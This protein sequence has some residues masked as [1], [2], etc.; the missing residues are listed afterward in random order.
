MLKIFPLPSSWFSI[1]LNASGSNDG[2]PPSPPGRSPCQAC[3]LE[4]TYADPIRIHHNR[5][6]L[7]HKPLKGFAVE[8]AEPF[9]H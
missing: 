8:V 9:G 2:T 3:H 1:I 7:A 5:A 6:A 4:Q